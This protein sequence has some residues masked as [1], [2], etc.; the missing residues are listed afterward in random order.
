MKN[1]LGIKSFLVLLFAKRNTCYSYYWISNSNSE[2]C[3][4]NGR[5]KLIDV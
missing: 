4:T 2:L 5:N 1:L 3:P